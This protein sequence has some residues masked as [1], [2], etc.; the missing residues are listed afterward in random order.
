MPQ[1]VASPGTIN[2]D[3]LDRFTLA[4]AAVG[5]V[6]GLA[7][8]GGAPVV[9]LALGWELLERPLK[10]AAPQLFPHATQDTAANAI[11]DAAAV[12]VG[13]WVVRRMRG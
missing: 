9:A 13:W 4:H 12:I 5:A 2:G 8:L 11:A 1:P 6:Y 7:G 10:D 3:M